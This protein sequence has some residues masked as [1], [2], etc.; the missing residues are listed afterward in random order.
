MAP[1]NS[2][3]GTLWERCF[4]ALQERKLSSLVKKGHSPRNPWSW[5]SRATG[6]PLEGSI[7][8][9]GSTLE[10]LGVSSLKT[11][12][13]GVSSSH[14][15]EKGKGTRLCFDGFWGTVSC[16]PGGIGS[17]NEESRVLVW[18][19]SE[20]V[21]TRPSSIHHL[22]WSLCQRR[23]WIL[24]WLLLVAAGLYHFVAAQTSSKL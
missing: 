23:V 3:R 22:F 14:C 16:S 13:S 10:S 12:G 8:Q 19:Y 6:E 21:V 11:A 7:P 24:R 18:L 5:A 15:P 4:N 9:K 17:W 20:F 2:N 1:V